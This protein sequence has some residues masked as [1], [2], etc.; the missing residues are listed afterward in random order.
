MTTHGGVHAC[1]YVV[2]L[3]ISEQ[4][5]TKTRIEGILRKPTNM[6]QHIEVNSE[7]RERV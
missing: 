5:N 7:H 2:L 6:I 4:W 3:A 1:I